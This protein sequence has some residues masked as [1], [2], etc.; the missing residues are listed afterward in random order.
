[1]RAAILHLS[2]S[3]LVEQDNPILKRVDKIAGALR[4]L[5]SF[6]DIYIVVSGDLVGF[7][8]AREYEIALDF[9]IKL[10]ERIKSNSDTKRLE[11]I[12]VPG[13]HDCNFNNDSQNRRLLNDSLRN[14]LDIT[15]KDNSVIETLCGIQDEFFDFLETLTNR[16]YEGPERL[17][18]E[19]QFPLDKNNIV[20]K[21]YNTAW[22]DSSENKRGTIIFP[23]QCLLQ[24]TNDKD[25]V[26]SVFHHPYLWF[27]V[28]N[29]R[30]FRRFI[31]QTSD[32]ILTGHEHEMDQ[33]IQK[34]I[35]GTES[36]F[37]NGGRL[38]GID[39]NESKFQVQ[40]IDTSNNTT[41]CVQFSWMDDM[42][43]QTNES[44]QRPLRRLDIGIYLNTPEFIEY[45]N[46]PGI[47]FVR[48]EKRDLKLDDI[49][50][51]PDVRLIGASAVASDIHY[52]IIPGEKLLDF[53]MENQR[54]VVLGTD[55][56]GKTVL[57]KS[58]YK[59][60]Q[61]M[62]LVPLLIESEKTLS[63]KYSMKKIIDES[64][65]QQYSEKMLGQYWQLEK[66]RRVILVDNFHL[67][68]DSK[69]KNSLVNKLIEF[70][71]VIVMAADNFVNISDLLGSTSGSTLVQF[72]HLALPDFSYETTGRLIEKWV[73]IR[74]Q[75]GEDEATLIYRVK[76]YEN[77]I[78]RFI[79]NKVLPAN[80]FVIL[81]LLQIL[82]AGGPSSPVSGSY[83]YLYEFLIT[84]AF[85]SVSREAED[86]DIKYNLL[87]YLANFMFEN[88][89]S[90]VGEENLSEIALAFGKYAQVTIDQENLKKE[91]VASRVMKSKDG[92]YCFAHPYVYHYFMARYMST[93]IRDPAANEEFETK[94]CH[95][96][97]NL[98]SNESANIIVFLCYLA[99]GD[100]SLIDKIIGRAQELFPSQKEFSFPSDTAFFDQFSFKEPVLTVLDID[101][102]IARELSRQALD[103]QQSE[104]KPRKI[105]SNETEGSIKEIV[106]EVRLAH[107]V[108][109]VL[110]QILRSFPGSRGYR[111]LPLAEGCCKLGMRLLS[112]A[113]QDLR[114]HSPTI[115]QDFVDFLK[116]EFPK[117]REEYAIAHA[118]SF[119]FMLGQLTSQ[120]I[121]KSVAMSIGSAR[122]A[123]L[124][125]EILSEDQS[126][127]FQLINICIRLNHFKAVPEREL[128][129]T[130]DAI[131]DRHFTS[132][133][134]KMITIDCLLKYPP[135]KSKQQ[136]IFARLGILRNL[137]P[138]V[139]RDLTK[140]RLLRQGR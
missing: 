98:Q 57:M 88:K 127:T 55:R 11:Y 19:Y 12:V 110:G 42:Y 61:N 71:N 5:G 85:S 94:I 49:F 17:S 116:Q 104:S 83:G 72:K 39:N 34:K 75:P 1:M 138:K 45:L 29:G 99:P 64:F 86:L 126:V 81:S 30:A 76:T 111:K 21:C 132:M 37:L 123:P 16:K 92:A 46:D 115:R 87:A 38:Q 134:L 56:S 120:N 78:N 107:S 44:E 84:G 28:E 65:V 89:I 73:R 68:G 140:A 101:P 59:D 43:T 113:V 50:V 26:C 91:L 139:I 69:L 48:P 58:L 121:I 96:I 14:N 4:S 67:L 97:N 7:G 100:A 22:M 35:A 3:H 80:P 27:D 112:A 51:Y 128:F 9:L 53:L 60:M 18:Y 133:L 109:H 40:I 25:I 118:N 70:T 103:S 31:E 36:Q 62:G 6:E 119:I 102:E 130:Y 82:E 20:F 95:F 135:S 106:A 124:Y 117:A 90:E 105:H 63:N 79:R 108:M 33:M 47:I 13:N 137:N 131:K 2:D 129:E 114:Q 10:D 77:S 23:N 8:K 74:Q 66:V 32:I 122:L 41:Q 136:S 125:D 24:R 93:I 15:F 52:T 54:I